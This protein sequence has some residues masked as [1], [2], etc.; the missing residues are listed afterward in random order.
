MLESTPHDIRQ[1]ANRR[2]NDNDDI[3]DRLNGLHFGMHAI[4]EQAALGGLQV[5]PGAI[6]ANQ[7][8]G[9]FTFSDCQAYRSAQQAG[10]DN[11]ELRK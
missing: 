4:K 9:K 3:I 10:A 7:S 5:A 1:D 8:F 2:A 11:D 6:N